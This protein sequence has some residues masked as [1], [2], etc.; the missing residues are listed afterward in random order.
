MIVR[1]EALLASLVVFVVAPAT[2]ARPALAAPTW[3]APSLVSTGDGNNFPDTQV[4]ID[5]AGDAVAVWPLSLSGDEAVI[6]SATRPFGGSWGIPVDVSGP[7]YS[8]RPEV[9]VDADGSEVAVWQHYDGSHTVVQAALRPEGGAWQE[10]VTLSAGGEEAED[11]QLAVDPSGEA[12]AIWRRNNGS[13]WIVQAS[14]CPPGGTF[15]P[16]V[17]LSA[18]GADAEDP[19]VAIDQHGDMVAVWDRF[20]GA[21]EI[22]QSSVREAGGAWQTPANLS[23]SGRNA[24]RPQVA[25]D[26][27]GE[28]VALWDR[29]NGSY[30]LV[31]SVS[32]PAGG[33]WQEPRDLSLPGADADAQ[34]IAVDARGDFVAVWEHPVGVVQSAVR[35]AGGGWQEPLNISAPPEDLSETAVQVAVDPKGDAVAVWERRDGASRNWVIQSAVRPAGGTWGEPNSLSPVSESAYYPVVAIDEFGDAV[36]VWGRYEHSESSILAAVLDAAPPLL[37]GLEIPTS[38]IVDE[39][40]GFAVSPLDPRALGATTWSFGEGAGA[41]GTSVTHAYAAAGDYRVTVTS[42]DAF[43]G[44][45]SASGTIAIAPLPVSRESPPVIT[46]ASIANRRFRVARGATAISA[47]SLPRGTAFRFTLSA[48][49]EL[50]VAIERA[51]PGLRVGRRCATPTKRLEHAHAR[52]CTRLVGIATLTRSREPAGADHLAFSGRIGRRALAAG[53]YDATLTASN[54]G[55]RSKTVTLM[56]TVIAGGYPPRFPRSATSAIASRTSSG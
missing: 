40:L 25:I 17:S 45:T 44:A 43:G 29:Y 38:G 48:A 22:V 31:Q 26:S 49:A 8:A 11:P 56:F 24:L 16:E 37:T 52:H 47:R 6:Q 19:A 20:D 12:I 39:P 54:G 51:A 41:A 14:V 28:A 9:A 18:A 35:P 1:L 42:A 50:K 46:A 4:A 5:P 27:E 23:A 33:S 2:L 10:P 36:A 30:I 7:G 55:G 34:Q 15:Q 53:A 32:R 21:N 3:L 13:N